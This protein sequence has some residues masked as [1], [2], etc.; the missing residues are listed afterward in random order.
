MVEDNYFV[1]KF[2]L[3]N[4]AIKEWNEMFK[5]LHVTFDG[6]HEK[7]IVEWEVHQQMIPIFRNTW[8]FIKEVKLELDWKHTKPIDPISSKKEK[9]EIDKI[10][11]GKYGHT[12]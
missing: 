3:D 2:N 9:R 7:E 12:G 10:I 1:K 4:Y 11:H 5:E 8:K 6:E